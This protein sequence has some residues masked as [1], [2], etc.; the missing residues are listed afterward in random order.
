M[1]QT[2]SN[3][4]SPDP[5]STFSQL[6]KLSPVIFAGYKV[7]HPLEPYFILK[8]QTDGSITPQRAFEDA[9]QALIALISELQV[10]FDKEFDMKSLDSVL[11]GT[12]SGAL[13]TYGGA[14]G[15][16][17]A[18]MGAGGDGMGWGDSRTRGVGAEY[19]DF[20]S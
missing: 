14:Y 12:G 19:L 10:K 2:V 18:G 11:G 6:L 9:C 15:A 5:I 3:S 17:G 20:G 4:P 16:G 7:P 1:S 13:G 8:V